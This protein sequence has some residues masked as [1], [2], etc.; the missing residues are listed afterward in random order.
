MTEQ[1]VAHLS[2]DPRSDGAVS[3]MARL[4]WSPRSLPHAALNVPALTAIKGGFIGWFLFCAA[5]LVGLA[6]PDGDS[7]RTWGDCL[8]SAAATALVGGAAGAVI[9]LTLILLFVPISEEES[10]LSGRARLNVWLM[11][12][13]CAML[14]VAVWSAAA[15]VSRADVWTGT[16]AWARSLPVMALGH[17]FWLAVF[18]LVSLPVT[19]LAARKAKRM[20]ASAAC[21]GC[22]YPLIGLTEPRCPECGRRV[23]PGQQIGPVPMIGTRR[24]IAPSR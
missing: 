17:P 21:I 13:Y 16:P 9:V 24:E 1:S 8:E 20:L 18:M 3:R 14:P 2:R 7:F 23:L 4:A 11:I 15:L 6:V 22:G 10:T 5:A 19:E 12:P